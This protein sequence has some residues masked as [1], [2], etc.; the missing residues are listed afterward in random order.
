MNPIYYSTAQLDAIS[1]AAQAKLLAEYSN[2]Y[3]MVLTTVQN[4]S[5][6]QAS[7]IYQA[8]NMAGNLTRAAE[9][10]DT[11]GHLPNSCGETQG[12]ALL[13]SLNGQIHSLN[14]T[15][16]LLLSEYKL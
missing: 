13:E 10:L 11:K 15:L 14:G 16:G 4:L 8:K 2:G 5:R 7:F 12:A 6:V 3:A 9:S 1:K